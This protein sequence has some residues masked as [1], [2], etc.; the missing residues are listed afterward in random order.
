MQSVNSRSVVV[1]LAHACL[2][3]YFKARVRVA[4][5]C[6]GYPHVL[7]DFSLYERWLG[8]VY[9]LRFL[10][11]SVGERVH[12]EP[13]LTIQNARN[14][15]CS[16]L[17][18]GN[19]VFIGPRFFVELALPVTLE[20]ECCLSPGVSIVTHSD[21]GDRR[22]L[23]SFGSERA[24]SSPAR[25]AT[26][27]ARPL[28]RRYDSRTPWRKKPGVRSASG[29][30]ELCSATCLRADVISGTFSTLPFGRSSEP[31]TFVL[32]RILRVAM[33]RNSKSTK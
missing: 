27:S 33:L 11:A 28:G 4:A 14:G 15:C 13:G 29:G 25:L 10:G 32:D 31:R 17:T 18:I 7:A 9:T 6:F 19:H 24:T 12:I 8:P 23:K 1:E 5:L 26:G 16:N 21:S 20:D 22:R 3:L 2:Q 30:G